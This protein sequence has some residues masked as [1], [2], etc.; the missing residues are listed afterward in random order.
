M[1]DAGCAG[2]SFFGENIHP[3]MDVYKRQ[4]AS[5][6]QFA[7]ELSRASRIPHPASHIPHLA[8]QHAGVSPT[9]APRCAANDTARAGKTPPISRHFLKHLEGDEQVHRRTTRHHRSH[10]RRLFRGRPCAA[11]RRAGLG[12]N[13]AGAHARGCGEPH[14]FAHPIYARPYACGHRRHEHHHR[15]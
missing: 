1:R 5:G 15:R 6:C 12:E 11:R 13:D 3:R 9:V 10:T 7:M 14:V 2:D 4:G 8:P